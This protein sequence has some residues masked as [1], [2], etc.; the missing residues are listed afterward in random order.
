MQSMFI[1]VNWAISATKKTHPQLSF[2][3]KNLSINNGNFDH[4]INVNIEIE[5]RYL[6]DSSMLW[7]KFYMAKNSFIFVNKSSYMAEIACYIL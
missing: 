5:T 4:H 2:K 1:G 6:D 3:W 7:L